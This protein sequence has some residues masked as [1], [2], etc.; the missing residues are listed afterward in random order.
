MTS[1]G[2][3]PKLCLVDTHGYGSKVGRNGQGGLEAKHTTAT[4]GT[5]S[6]VFADFAT[7]DTQQV[8]QKR[9]SQRNETIGSA[10]TSWWADL[11]SWM[12]APAVLGPI[13]HPCKNP[14]LQY[15]K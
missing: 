9:W 8:R 4:F 14:V 2:T 1:S 15:Q 10:T 3:S 13:Q 7:F 11:P 5:L 12:V 6:D